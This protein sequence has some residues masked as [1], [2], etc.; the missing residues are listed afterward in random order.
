ME[1]EW[2]ETHS[3]D[4][5][6]RILE[7]TVF[8]TRHESAVTLTSGRDLW[9]QSHI[10]GSLFADLINDLS[11]PNGRFRFT[12]PSE[13]RFAQA[14]SKLGIDKE[15]RIVIYDRAGTGWSARL[16][17]MLRYFGF[18]N[19]AV[20][21]GGWTKWTAENRAVTAETRTIRRTNF[22][23]RICPGW[24]SGITDVIEAVHGNASRI[25]YALDAEKYEG[26]YIP[27][28]TTVTAADLLDPR[29]SALL[30][31]NEIK[32][33]FTE[34]GALDD[35]PVITYCGSGIAASLNAFILRLLGKQNVTVFDG[36]LLEWMA[37]TSLP[38]SRG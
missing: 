10:P 4:P 15:T 19:A 38:L 16:W 28:S 37:D 34:A 13:K 7:S 12:L 9:E 26:K 14:M 23:A 18:E 30:S 36:G 27:G 11:D 35:Y 33:R 24:F 25:L 8:L 3:S 21:N 17:W 2:L 22:K 29:T 5:D 20:L 1:T 6:L 31:L 32:K